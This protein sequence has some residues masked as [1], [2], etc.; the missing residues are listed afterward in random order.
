MKKNITVPLPL[1]IEQKHISLYF[2][3]CTYVFTPE[4]TRIR[5]WVFVTNTGFCMNN[6]GLIKDCHHQ[7]P[8][9][10]TNYQN[11]AAQYYYNV[12][13]DPGQ[14]IELDDQ[15]TYLL[16]HHPWFNYF[17]WITESIFR[18]WSVRKK[19]ND[20]VLIL[21]ESYQHVDFI[22]GSLAPFELKNIYFIPSGKSLMVKTLCLPPVKRICD[23]FDARQLKS[24]R[25][26]YTEYVLQIND[27]VELPGEKLYISRELASR[28]K[29]TNEKAIQEVV[30][31][32]GFTVFYP[33]RFSFLKQVA[34]F[35]KIKFL[36]GTHGS[37]LTNILFM[38]ENSSVLELHKNKTNELDHPSPLFW[39]MSN[40]LKINYFHQLCETD[41]P[42]DY[43][44]GNYLV[45]T[46]LLEKNLKLM[47]NYEESTTAYRC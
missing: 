7:F 41:G 24:V 28:R 3:N 43:F 35:A 34:I 45:D 36:I 1:N 33:E 2:D 12:V 16:I 21:P 18:L 42:E 4:R 14:L 13:D 37:G 6:R 30:T 19:N 44:E 29:I 31:K 8:H 32:Y 22:M 5:T 23:S 17:H 20:L 9:Q 15:R 46:V 11:E 40:G 10:L 39:Y 25:K 38:P 26:F 27:S 47:L